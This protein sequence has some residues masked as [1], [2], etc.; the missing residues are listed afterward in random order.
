MA[1]LMYTFVVVF[2]RVHGAGGVVTIS[3]VTVIGWFA[4]VRFQMLSQIYQVL[5]AEEIRTKHTDELILM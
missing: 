2:D 3:K 5:T 4:A 1:H